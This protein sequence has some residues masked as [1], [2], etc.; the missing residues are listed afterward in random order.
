MEKIKIPK[1]MDDAKA[2]GTVLS[3]YKD[4]YYTQVLVAY[5]ATYVLYPFR[6]FREEYLCFILI[7]DVFRYLDLKDSLGY[8]KNVW[9]NVLKHSQYFSSLTKAQQNQ[10]QQVIWLLTVMAGRILERI[11]PHKKEQLFV[12]KSK[13]SR[14][15]NSLQMRTDGKLINFSVTE[16]LMHWTK[17][18]LENISTPLCI[19]TV[20]IWKVDVS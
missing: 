10:V 9:E 8:S 4:T 18:N 2:L 7:G 19:Y 3:K 6:A 13:T 15:S 17:K 12:C 16:I 11:L 14:S 1:D 20:Y 5:F